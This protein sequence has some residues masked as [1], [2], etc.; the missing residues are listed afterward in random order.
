MA[1]QAAN[2]LDLV[3]LTLPQFK[4]FKFSDNSSDYQNTIAFKRIFNQK[5]TKNDDG[6]GTSIKFQLMTD[7]NGS[8]RFV[9]IGF[10]AQLAMPSTFIQGETPWRGWTW[11]WSV[12]GVEPAMQGSATKIF[13]IMKARFFAGRGDMIKGT[14]RALWRV[15]SS[16]SDDMLGIPYY[17]VK[18]NTAATLA[19]NDGFNGLVPSGWSTVAG[20]NPTTYPRWRNYA[21]QYTNVTKTDWA[22]KARRMAE[23]IRFMPLVDDMPVYDTGMDYA[24]YMN[25][26][27]YEAIVEMAESQNDNLGADVAAMDG[28]KVMF[29]RAKCDWLPELESDTTNPFYMV[30]WGVMYA[31]RQKGWF[32][33]EIKVDLN[34]QQPTMASVHYVTRANLVCLDRRKC[35]VIATDTT[36]PS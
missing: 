34:P 16:T 10:T 21:T 1:T 9:G 27:L 19:N 31:A 6:D 2:I 4:K 23:K 32:E 17:I 11:N 35:G 24:S 36:M 12:D 5:K 13:D 29:R 22:R 33:K 8:F 14:E 15:P 30:D 26:G 7:T 28:N 25:Y 3:T 20:I 18:S